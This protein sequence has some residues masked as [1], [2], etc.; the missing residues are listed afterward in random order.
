M[1]PAPCVPRIGAPITRSWWLLCP[2]HPAAVRPMLSVQKGY[3]TFMIMRKRKWPRHSV[4]HHSI[5]PH[6]LPLPLVTTTT[7]TTTMVTCPWRRP[8]LLVEMSPVVILSPWL[9]IHS[10]FPFPAHPRCGSAARPLSVRWPWEGKFSGMG[11]NSSFEQ[12]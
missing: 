10:S 8:E 11:V 1:V 3:G 5:P 12:K 4:Q 6:Y 9:T 2:T 7:I